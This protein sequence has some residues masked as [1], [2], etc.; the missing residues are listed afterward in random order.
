MHSSIDGFTLPGM[1]ED[2]GCTA[3]RMISASPVC[4]PE[5]S[6]RRSFVIR[7]SSSA[8]L[9]YAPD[10]AET[11]SCDCMPSRKSSIALNSSFVIWLRYF[12]TAKR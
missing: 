7:V 2:P 12:T 9:R 5:A 10:V 4:G 3:G 8:R 11:G 6:K 1:I